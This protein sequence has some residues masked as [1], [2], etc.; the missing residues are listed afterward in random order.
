MRRAHR[1]ALLLAVVAALWIPATAIGAT[2]IA[3]TGSP[4]AWVYPES[5]GDPG[6]VCLYGG[7][8]GTA[9]LERI[10]MGSR[11]RIRGVTASLRSVAYR[12]IV[13]QLVAGT[14]RSVRYG[15]RHTAYATTAGYAAIDPGAIIVPV[16]PGHDSASYRLALRLI[17]YNADASI[18]G[19]RTV[20]VTWHEGGTAMGGPVLGASCRGSYG[21]F[22]FPG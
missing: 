9:Y 5:I 7:A 4:G 21:N 18:L 11:V 3:R 16:G 17:W 20:A 22:P 8:A 14:W 10:R 2:Q 15:I 12:P 13:Q 6:A 1:P 19:T